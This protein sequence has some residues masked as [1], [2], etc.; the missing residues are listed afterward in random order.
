MLKL[1]FL[2]CTMRNGYDGPQSTVHHN[3]TKILLKEHSYLLL[4][5]VTYTQ[6]LD[7]AVFLVWQKFAWTKSAALKSLI[8][9]NAWVKEFLQL[10]TENHISWIFGLFFENVHEWKPHHWNRQEPRTRCTFPF[11][12]E[13][14]WRFKIWWYLIGY[15]LI[16]LWLVCQIR[17]VKPVVLIKL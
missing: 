4:V 3:G 15:L 17:N 5:I 2:T 8:T 7:R 6:S 13:L 11:Y 9:K 1:H 12:M 10:C 16:L 14:L